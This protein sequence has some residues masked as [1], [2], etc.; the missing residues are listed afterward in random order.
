MALNQEEIRSCIE[1][2]YRRRGDTLGW[3][4]LYSPWETMLNADVAF[5]GLQPGGGFLPNDH[6]ELCMTSGSAYVTESWTGRPAGAHPLQK[7]VRALFDW[8]DVA[9]EAVLAGNLVPF[10]CPNARS[11]KDMRGALAFGEWLWRDIVAQ[12]RPKLVVTMSRDT[13]AA[14]K[15]VGG[16]DTLQS[17]P[18]GWGSI[19]LFHG[20]GPLFRLI[21]L[22][23]LSRF[24]IITRPASREALLSVLEH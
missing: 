6:G 13:T 20:E 10:R 19:R 21:G 1:K 24:G 7:Q 4:L 23:H 3:R 22:P 14:F 8:L 18:C 17:R 2:E 9:P 12:A 5:L 11:F 15:R 16:I